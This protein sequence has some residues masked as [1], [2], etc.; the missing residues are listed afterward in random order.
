M[1]HIIKHF[2]PETSPYP[3]EYIAVYLCVGKTNKNL[4]KSVSLPC[5]LQLYVLSSIPFHSIIL[6]WTEMT[7][8]TVLV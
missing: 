4:T 7:G 5:A 3:P 1:T 6:K 2:V 8:H